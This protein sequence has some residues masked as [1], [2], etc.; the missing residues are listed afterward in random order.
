[1]LN[2]V[3][4]VGRVVEMPNDN[5]EFVIKIPRPEGKESDLVTIAL[6]DNIASNVHEYCEEKCIVGIKGRIANVDGKL[7]I[8][9]EKVTFLTSKKN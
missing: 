4:L 2:Q 5:N 8:N 1:M 6:S 7:V 9:A 3:V